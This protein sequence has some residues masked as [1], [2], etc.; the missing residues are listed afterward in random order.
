M[1]KLIL[2]MCVFLISTYIGFSYGE[3][4][5][6]RQAQ[7]KEILKALTILE[8]EI[9]YGA[10]PLPE[11]LE[12]LSHKVDKPLSDFIKAISDRLIKGDVESVYEGA[13]EEYSR[14][15]NEFF[16]YDDDKKVLGDFFKSLGESGVYGQEKIFFLAVEGIKMNLSDAEDNAKRNIK[17]YRY[18]GICLGAMIVIFII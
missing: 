13:L 15:K 10:T 6:K 11:A 7:L 9:V 12:N 16:I 14:F 18:L 8:N 3:T 5:R 4:F 1:L 2:A 17:L